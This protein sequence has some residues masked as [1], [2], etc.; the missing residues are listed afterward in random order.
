M[1]PPKQEA[2]S[3]NSAQNDGTASYESCES[4]MSEHHPNR[5]AFHRAFTD[6]CDALRKM[7]VATR[8]TGDRSKDS[9]LFDVLGETAG[10]VAESLEK[11]E[12]VRSRVRQFI[13]DSTH[14]IA[15]VFKE[16]SKTPRDFIKA[17]NDL[18]LN[19]EVIETGK[20]RVSAESQAVTDDETK[21][22]GRFVRDLEPLDF[23]DSVSYSDF[24]DS[25]Y[26]KRLKQMPEIEASKEDWRRNL[27]AEEKEL[28]SDER[29]TMYAESYP[30]REVYWRLW[31][32]RDWEAVWKET[33]NSLK[34]ELEKQV[35]NLIRSAKDEKRS[36]VGSLEGLHLETHVGPHLERNIYNG[37][38]NPSKK[39]LARNSIAFFLSSKD[40][41]Y[42]EVTNPQFYN[43]KKYTN[44]NDEKFARCWWKIL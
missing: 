29:D 30:D 35:S 25:L 5:Q 24:A 32:Y 17:V 14:K 6:K 37:L 36:E 11:S 28:S 19:A 2:T 22:S 15:S 3:D 9:A 7:V 13:E 34:Y 1:A 43:L 33:R 8:I 16:R 38:S 31:A 41:L 27:P 12:Q 23:K 26:K 21:L 20:I 10:D 4:L 39:E 44:I 42:G 40:G 18:G